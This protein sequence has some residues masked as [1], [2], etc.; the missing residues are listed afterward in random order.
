MATWTEFPSWQVAL[1]R[2]VTEAP[3]CSDGVPVT[4]QAG[5]SVM[6]ALPCTGWRPQRE[7]TGAPTR[8]ALGTIDQDAGTVT[9]TAG[10]DAGTDQVR[11]RGVN[12][13]GA[14]AKHSV[15]VTVT[16]APTTP[17]GP[18]PPPPDTTDRTPPVVSGL[19]LKPKRLSLRKLRS[20]GLGFSLSEPATVKVAVQRVV[21]GRRKRGRCVTKPPP[22]RGARCVKTTT[23]KR[24][25]ATLPA[26][27]A[28]LRIALRRPLSPGSY[29][30]TISATDQAGNRSNTLQASL[31]IS[32]R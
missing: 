31:T 2:Y 9:Y 17:G 7:V 19:S 16:P 28:Q 4:V 25:T 15:A 8:G 29:R 24:V 3:A 22:R 21:K 5:K 10:A 13:A 6:L 27:P 30:V 1:S 12:G 20:T 14:S 11:F 32:R 18:N 26:G 23:V